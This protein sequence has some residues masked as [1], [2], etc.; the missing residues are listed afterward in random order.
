MGKEIPA[1]V[2]LHVGPHEMAPVGHH[3]IHPA[4]AKV[5]Q[6]HEGHNGK[7]GLKQ[8]LGQQLPHGGSGD[9]GKDQ[10]YHSDHQGADHIQQKQVDMGFVIVGKQGELGTG[11]E[12]F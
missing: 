8:S 12:V 5:G 11:L 4:L 6:E 2:G 9:V 10:I 3:K 1:D 7:E